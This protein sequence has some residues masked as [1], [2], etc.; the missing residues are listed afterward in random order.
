MKDS[1][2][3]ALFNRQR[4]DDYAIAE[5]HWTT[6]KGGWAASGKVRRRKIS[7][8]YQSSLTGFA[9]TLTIFRELISFRLRRGC[10]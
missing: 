4:A 7:R 1:E 9:G 2:V 5:R 6:S 3:I 10:P 8:K